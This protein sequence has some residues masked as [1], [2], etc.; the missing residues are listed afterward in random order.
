[1]NWGFVPMTDAELEYMA[2]NLKPLIDPE[3]ALFAFVREEPAGFF[4]AL[5]DYNLILKD[6]KGRL[7]P[8][9]IFRLLFGRRK[10]GRVRVM[11]LGVVEK[12]RKMGL[13]AVLLDEVYRRGPARGYVEGELSWILEDNEPMNRIIRRLTDEPYRVYRIYGRDL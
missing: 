1:R 7:F 6:L 3:M 5:P 11:I 8:T 10:I 12:Y 4:L 9:G 2:K 13:E